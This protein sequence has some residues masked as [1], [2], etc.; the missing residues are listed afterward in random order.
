MAGVDSRSRAL[1]ALVL[2]GLAAVLTL[3]LPAAA[4][5]AARQS[6]PR[7]RPLRN[8]FLSALGRA[9]RT[10]SVPGSRAIRIGIAV[11][12]PHPAAEDA[13]LK[14]LYDRSSPSF[15]RFLSPAA[16]AKRFGV[17][18]A[19]AAQV[20]AWA[21]ST[22]L[23][24]RYTSRARDYLVASG[25]VAQVQRLTHT[26]LGTYRFAG[27]GFIAN[28]APPKVPA[29]LPIYSVLGLN[30]YERFHTMHE[31]GAAVASHPAR[32]PQSPQPD[33][34]SR[35]PQQL[36]SIYEQP[37]EHTGQGV[38]VAVLGEGA[39]DSVIKDLHVFDQKNGFKQLPVSVVHT[40]VNGKFDDTSGNPEWNIDM[41]AIHGMAPDISKEVLYF[42][43]SLA[44]TDLVA[45]TA[46]WVND[47]SGP[48]I[49]NAS[50]GEC[51]V[52]PLNPVLNQQ[53]L[54]PINGNENQ[55]AAPA[56]Q[57]LSNSSEPAQAMLLKQAVMEGRT[58]FASSGDAGSSC[59]ALYA[60][61]IGAGNGVVNQG[62]P[63][64]EDPADS[65]YATGVGGTVL[66][67][68]SSLPGA[69]RFLEYAWT[70]SGGNASPFITAPGYQQ[71]VPN[72]DRKC[73]SDQSGG[74]TNTGQLCRG[75]PD[76]AA[77]SGDVVSNGYTIISDGQESTGGGTSLSSPL[78]AGM[79]ARVVGTA[80]SGSSGYGFANEAIYR[81]AKDPL[82]YARSFF[83][84]TLGSNGLNS[85][86]PGYDYVTG[87]GT[88]RLKSLIADVQA[89]AP[90]VAAA[91]GTSPVGPGSENAGTKAPKCSDR[92]APVTRF[93]GKRTFGRKKLV[94]RG[95]SR[96]KGCGVH[97][98]GAVRTVYVSV[99]RV[100]KTGCS[101]MNAKGRLTKKRSCRKAILLPAKGHA[102]WLLSMRVHL[103]AA[104]YRVVARARDTTG[105]R[106]KPHSGK[107]VLKK[108]LR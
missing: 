84:V 80:P 45:S 96:D 50:L 76:V 14:A 64:T 30:T 38:S 106:E 42:A 68:D 93:K 74:T 2:T 44:D 46:T 3:A 32:A 104:N 51:E 85:A 24:V 77:I 59:A 60:P 47:P 79:W 36:W 54:Y 12:H 102:S 90:A 69:G 17:G 108:H 57:G 67:S 100:L 31:E 92:V 56:S 35:T 23:K 11:G 37:A 13:Y 71:G 73:V 39:T 87:F 83:D 43:P 53:A 21:R 62:V 75:V 41:Q 94:L 48:P 78:W 22:G 26:T 8:D 107:N 105:N 58:F 7:L 33:P 61:E 19:S 4:A 65:P 16:F 40:P 81:I 91:G 70:F 88:P 29:N 15:H 66:Y 52:S 98:A 6:T 103:P 34:G 82:R 95:T 28:D 89:V 101:F 55:M 49:M 20:S 1:A 86:Q 97:G 63:L 72:L 99:A 10:G 25:T 5:P 9:T 18:K 27:A